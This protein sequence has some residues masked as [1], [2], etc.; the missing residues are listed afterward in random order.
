MNIAIV[1]LGL[2]GGS[3]AKDLRANGFASKL[4]GVDSSS[5]HRRVALELG[6]VDECLPLEDAV[7]EADLV[8][9]AI[10]VRAL[11]QGMVE[12]LNQIDEDA[13]V[14]DMGSTKAEI[15]EAIQGHP[16]RKRAVLAHPMAG[17]EYSG[18][19]AAVSNLFQ[20]KAAIICDRDDS[21]PDAVRLAERMFQSL[22]MRVVYMESKEHDV[23][24]AY[25]S[26]ISHISSF[27]LALTVLEKEASS[28]N[29]FNLASGGF[30]STV[31]LAKSNPT[32]WRDVFEQNS[33]NLLD[34][35]DNYLE[36]VQDFRNDIAQGDFQQAFRRME[37]ANAIGPILDQVF[38]STVK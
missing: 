19:Q 7:F 12:V 14:V 8:V 33:Q 24:A 29:I 1:G 22:F 34:V 37:Q 13:V 32:M 26:H 25:V 16:L 27:A 36:H 23:H 35:L 3:L 31:R 38:E 6:L 17:T 2:I 21:D 30:R 4:T 5:I 28:A 10:P 15:A 9:L 18:P 11:C 20:G